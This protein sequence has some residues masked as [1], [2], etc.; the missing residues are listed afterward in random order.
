MDNSENSGHPDFGSSIIIPEDSAS[1]QSDGEISIIKEKTKKSQDSLLDPDCE[2]IELELKRANKTL[3]MITECNKVLLHSETEQ[4]LLNSICE[5][6]IRHG[7]YFMCWIGYI[8]E[9]GEKI[10]H[11][12]ARA[13]FDDGYLDSIE[14]SWD[15]NKES[16]RGPTGTAIREK[17]P[18]YIKNVLTDPTFALWRDNA[19]KRG[20]NSS[21][22]LPLFIKNN[23]VGALCLYAKEIEVFN[24][25]EIN[26][27]EELSINIS[28]CIGHIRDKEEK[29]KTDEI[30]RITEE[31]LQIRQRMDSLGTLA[32]GF[33]H[34]FNNLLA[35]IMGYLELL[36]INGALS[37]I[38][39]NYVQNA[40]QGGKR[41]AEL[42]KQL[43]S[44][45]RNIISEKTS[46]DIY[47]IATEVFYLLDKSTDKII[48]KIVNLNK[49]DF[50]VLGNVSELH[51]V[52]LNLG[53]NSFK[54]IEE[55]G[56]KDGDFIKISAQNYKISN[57]DKTGLPEGDYVHISFE[58]NGVGMS[59]RVLRRAF[60][61][62]FTTREKCA[63]KGQ[64]LGLAMVYNIITKIHKGHIYIESKEGIGTTMHIFLPKAQ[65]IKKEEVKQKESINKIGQ[66]TILIIEDEEMIQSFLKM[67]LEMKGY[68]VITASDGKEGLKTYMDNIN[69]ID[70]VILDLTMPKMSGQEVLEKM[71]EIKNNVKVIISSGQSDESARVGILSQ[72]KG[73]VLKPYTLDVLYNTIGDVLNREEE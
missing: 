68:D 6:I 29:K 10:V 22:A 49:G 57:L 27:L 72:A 50:Y 17:H 46:V 28:Q 15:E 26:L 33:A 16:G 38:H 44:L 63:Q 69:S 36:N 41:A 61:P 11:P 3:K 23:V 67:A 70:L 62:L 52:L 39:R 56:A 12:V 71:L 32:G 20:Y 34:D 30:L 24:N 8:G 18:V 35:G 31:Q 19:I 58:D 4:D 47:D 37:D 2:D 40:L 48:N 53:I 25:E 54:A 13:G 21:L 55:K 66:K 43:Q 64:G 14:I 65:N 45:S 7:G 73:Y 42:V 1:S 5:I 59:D 9:N 60:D 51:Q